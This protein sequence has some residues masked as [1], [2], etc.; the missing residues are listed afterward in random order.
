[1]LSVSIHKAKAHFSS[2]IA[3]V[4]RLGETVIIMRHGEAVA[5]IKPLPR[6]NRLAADPHLARI[7]MLDDPVTPTIEEWADA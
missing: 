3:D 7:S 1:M 5:E 2:L 4:E 6:G